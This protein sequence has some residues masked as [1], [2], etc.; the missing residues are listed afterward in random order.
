MK[1]EDA[2]FMTQYQQEQLKLLEQ[3]LLQW[4]ETNEILQTLIV[5]EADG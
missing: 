3:M 5:M 1:T 2:K 4:K